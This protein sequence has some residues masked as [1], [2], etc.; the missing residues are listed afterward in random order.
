MAELS[1]PHTG[2]L[3]ELPLNGQTIKEKGN[4]TAGRPSMESCLGRDRPSYVD[5]P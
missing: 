2:D 5:G 4:S 3:N 1:Q